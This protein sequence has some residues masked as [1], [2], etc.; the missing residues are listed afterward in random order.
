MSELFQVEE[1]CLA[2]RVQQSVKDARMYR[3]IEEKL[4]PHAV[5]RGVGDVVL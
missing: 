2:R 3:D 1:A 5:R 4:R